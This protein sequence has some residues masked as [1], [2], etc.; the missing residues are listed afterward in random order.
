MTGVPPKARHV[1][2]AKAT[3]NL[4]NPTPQGCTP[5]TKTQACVGML[6]WRTLDVPAVHG[7]VVAVAGQAPRGRPALQ[8]ADVRQ[9]LPLLPH[10]RLQLAGVQLWRCASCQ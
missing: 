10:L 2:Q 1:S 7:E 6:F 3:F 9:Q 8:P 4:E 5:C